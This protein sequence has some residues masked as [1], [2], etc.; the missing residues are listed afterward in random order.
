MSSGSKAETL[1]SSIL[2][3]NSTLEHKVLVI[4]P[5]SANLL[6][7]IELEL[8][9]FYACRLIQLQKKRVLLRQSV[10]FMNI[11]VCVLAE[12]VTIDFGTRSD[13]S[14]RE[15]PRSNA[16]AWSLQGGNPS[17]IWF[18]W[19]V[20]DTTQQHLRTNSSYIFDS[21]S[22]RKDPSII[23]T[24]C[25]V[26]SIPLFRIRMLHQQRRHRWGVVMPLWRQMQKQRVLLR[27]SVRFM[28]ISVCVLAEN[29]TIDFGTRSD[30]SCRELPR[31][32]ATAGS[33]QGGNPSLVWFNWSVLDTS[34]QHLR[35]NGSCQ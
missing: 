22:V 9:W 29:V 21:N 34:Q 18:N 17:L 3:R 35:T 33:L 23:T 2:L 26:S 16:T 11:S 19:S 27:Q 12:N 32:N 7:F 10:R 6:Y 5:W 15:L 13:W 1:E 24:L 28:N 25:T 14:C 4:K 20:L 8:I 31:S 30:W